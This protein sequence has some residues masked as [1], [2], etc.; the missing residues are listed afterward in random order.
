MKETETYV[1]MI[2]DAFDFQYGV[3]I[4]RL[5]EGLDLSHIQGQ[6]NVF[7]PKDDS[8]GMKDVVVSID[9][10]KDSDGDSSK[11]SSKTTSVQN[12]PAVQK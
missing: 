7:V 12:S 2:H 11:L 6:D 1:N 4:L 5:R 8:S 3:V 9:M 10:S